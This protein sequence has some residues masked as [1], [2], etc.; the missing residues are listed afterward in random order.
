MRKDPPAE[1][2]A[3]RALAWLVADED[4]LPVFLNATGANADDLRARAADPDFL[5]AVLDFVLLEDDWVLGFAAAEGI[6]PE[7]VLRARAG[8]PGGQQEHW[9]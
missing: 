1:V 8:L 5:A 9:T 6:A 2:T 4:I 7:Q 3:L